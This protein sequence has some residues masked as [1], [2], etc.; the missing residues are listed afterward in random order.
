[1]LDQINTCDGL[2]IK[3]TTSD[4]IKFNLLPTN[5]ADRFTTQLYGSKLNCSVGVKFNVPQGYRAAI[6]LGTTFG[7]WGT[8]STSPSKFIDQAGFTSNRRPVTQFDT[9]F[10]PSLSDTLGLPKNSTGDLDLQVDTNSDPQHLLHTGCGEQNAWFYVRPAL[11]TQA[12][13]VLKLIA[14]SFKLEAC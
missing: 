3:L 9:T 13:V 11:E 10:G 14:A 4:G 7:V 2:A 6:R 5:G 1:V 12:T 8:T